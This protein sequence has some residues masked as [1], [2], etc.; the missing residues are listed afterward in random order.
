VRSRC[1]RPERSSDRR[2]A[3]RSARCSRRGSGVTTRSSG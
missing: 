2:W 3:P 1:R